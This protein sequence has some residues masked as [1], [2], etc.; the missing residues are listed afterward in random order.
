MPLL[1]DLKPGEK[2]IINGAVIENAGANTKLR[3]HNESN[4]LRQ[5]EILVAEEVSTPAARVYFCLQNAYI[6][7]DKR[8][9]YLNLFNECLK[10][11]IEA[12][13]SAAP[14]A[15]EIL[16]E[17]VDGHYYRALKTSRRLLGHE[18]KVL[19]SLRDS[20][21]KMSRDLDR[22]DGEPKAEE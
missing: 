12:C 16:T 17:L 14:I 7:P 5:K 18:T 6:F 15:Q 11:F 10:Q 1:I 8:D 22:L 2:V 4:I 21:E 20:A 9:Y 3:L 19:E 13:P